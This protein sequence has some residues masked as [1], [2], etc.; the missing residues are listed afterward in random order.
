ML[1]FCCQLIH[2]Q[3]KKESLKSDVDKN[4]LDT[5][6]TERT[7]YSPLVHI[8]YNITVVLRDFLLSEDPPN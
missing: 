4:S 2:N 1:K 3:V 8:I 7:R 6:P 5:P